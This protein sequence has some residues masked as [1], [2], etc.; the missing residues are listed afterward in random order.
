MDTNPTGEPR[1][2]EPLPSRACAPARVERPPLARPLPP[3]QEAGTGDGGYSRGALLYTIER[4]SLTHRPGMTVANVVVRFGVVWMRWRVVSTRSGLRAFPPSLPFQSGGRTWHR[5]AGGVDAAIRGQLEADIVAAT[6]ER[7]RTEGRHPPA[8]PRVVRAPSTLQPL[9]AK[10]AEDLDLRTAREVMGELCRMLN[11][12]TLPE[13]Q[14]LQ[15][16]TI[17][18]RVLPQW[19]QT[20]N[21]HLDAYVSAL[22]S[23]G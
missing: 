13:R 10:L 18:A 15:A 4:V 11:D 2:E 16:A 7:L 8:P 5:R 1:S 3:G 14:R 12:P 21:K 20:A 19:L 9:L 17:W 22:G 6:E 23:I